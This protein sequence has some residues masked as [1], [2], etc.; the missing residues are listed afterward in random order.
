MEI[1]SSKNLP[2]HTQELFLLGIPAR[3]ILRCMFSLCK[4]DAMKLAATPGVSLLKLCGTGMPSPRKAAS[5]RPFLC[6]IRHE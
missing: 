1:T 6:K 3:S 5:I 2:T 4:T